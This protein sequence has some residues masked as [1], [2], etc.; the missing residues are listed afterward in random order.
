M[1][2]D[3]SSDVPAFP[4]SFVFSLPCTG[5]TLLRLILDTHPEIYCPDE[6]RLGNVVRALHHTTEGL[7]E[8][9]AAPAFGPATAGGAPESAAVV[10]T[11]RIVCDLMGQAAARKGKTRWCDKSPSNL[12]SMRLIARVLPAARNILLHRHCLDMTQSCLKRSTFGFYLAIVED[13]VRK[14]H[15]DFLTATI[16]AWV[17]QTEELLRFEA[18]H[19]GLCH[20]LRY[21][22]LVTAPGAAVES[23]F[24]FL[25][26]PFTPAILAGVFAS[27]R[28]QR[29]GCG[30][31]AVRYSQAIVDKSVGSGADLAPALGRVPRDL[32]QRMNDLLVRLGYPAVDR[33]A[34]GFDA[35][36][37]RRQAPARTGETGGAG[38]AGDTAA[39]AAAPALSLADVFTGLA[40]RLR[41]DP[42]FA[43]KVG[44]SFQFDLTGPGGGIWLL[45]LT[46]APG[47]VHTGPAP[48]DVQ[49]TIPA[50]D[51]ADVLTGALNPITAIKQGRLQLAGNVDERAL[52]QLFAGLFSG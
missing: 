37:D 43:P 21:E 26:V 34:D 15:R 40:E 3:H 36:L 44:Q 25:Q 50:A 1:P 51:F 19:A 46:A 42:T 52:Q 18:D 14:N 16:L 38:Q 41:L 33:T 8:V 17:E 28:F 32:F 22:D 12:G 2:A 13:Y 31:A 6:V 9:V 47:A 20:R 27:P 24:A 5:S 7:Y 49:L 23:L 35:H 30:D 11:R 4:G 48:S 10:E 45:D 29:Q 39:P